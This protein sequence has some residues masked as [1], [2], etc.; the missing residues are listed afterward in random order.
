MEPLFPAD[1]YNLL[2]LRRLEAWEP[3][4]ARAAEPAHGFTLND[5]VGAMDES[6]HSVRMT[7]SKID[8]QSR[9]QTDALNTL[10][11]QAFELSESNNRLGNEFEL[12]GDRCQAVAPE[13]DTMRETVSQLNATIEVLSKMAL[14][15]RSAL[16]Q[17]AKSMRQIVEIIALVRAVSDKTNLLALNARIEAARAGE[18]GAGFNVVA[19][20]VRSLADKTKASTQEIRR[21]LAELEARGKDA[22]VAI[23]SGVA[24]AEHS[25]RQARAAQEAFKRIEAFA[26]SAQATLAEAQKAARDESSRSHAM[27][28]DYS[29]MAMLV[30]GHADDSK[31]ALTVTDELDAQRKAL[32]A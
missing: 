26:A 27:Y 3:R 10:A 13:V 11:G 20:E 14:Q 6:V 12:L 32:F 29:Q 21:V 31:R 22:A 23:G 16:E 8:Q 19:G 1:V 2:R 24:K 25:S 30:E 15:S 9:S 7:G 5:I 18:H 28:G 4:R 17:F